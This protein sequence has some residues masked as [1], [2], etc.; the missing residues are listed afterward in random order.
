MLLLDYVAGT[1]QPVCTLIWVPSKG[2]ENKLRQNGN[3]RHI[4]ILELVRSLDVWPA[5][6]ENKGYIYL[7]FAY[8]HRYFAC[9]DNVKVIHI[10][11]PK[12]IR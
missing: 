8:G 12:S 5:R 3:D 6:L 11:T 9:A 4:R 10:Y 1:F 2:E 7:D